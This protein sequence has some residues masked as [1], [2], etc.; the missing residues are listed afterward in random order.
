MGYRWPNVRVAGAE[1]SNSAVL[2]TKPRLHSVL[3][4]AP[5]TRPTGTSDPRCQG[6]DCITGQR[7][8]HPAGPFPQAVIAT[9]VRWSAR[10]GPM[11]LGLRLFL[12]RSALAPDARKI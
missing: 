12:P 5:A 1:R 6:T 8:T 9:T 4:R 7:L 2:A 3:P 11:L 10:L